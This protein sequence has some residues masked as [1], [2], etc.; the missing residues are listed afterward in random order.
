MPYAPVNGI[1]LFYEVEGSG[2]PVVLCHGVG[3]NHLSWWQ[4]VPVLAQRYT[5]VILDQ[6]GFCNTKLP[7]GGPYAEAFADDVLGLLDHLELREPTFLVGQSMGGRTTLDF[8]RRYPERTRGIVLADTLAN[9]RSPALD[10]ARREASEAVGADRLRAALSETT[11]RER[12][13]LGFLYKLIRGYNKP[14][15]KTFYWKNNVPGATAADLDGFAIPA[16]FIAGAED[17]IAPPSAIRMGY[18]MFPSARWLEVPG[19]GHSVYFEKPDVFNAALLDFFS[20]YET[21]R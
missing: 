5:C 11:W 7:E 9:L 14:R 1:E 4:Q 8:A 6:R 19:A 17:R 15:P 3:G 12:P 13:D 2:I 21:G 20:E 18:E 10:T 16:L